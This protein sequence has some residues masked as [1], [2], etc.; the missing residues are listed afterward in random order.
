MNILPASS[1]IAPFAWVFD[2]RVDHNKKVVASLNSVGIEALGE[3]D[4]S[5][6][7]D[8]VESF[9][10]GDGR[11][12]DLVVIDQHWK[13]LLTNLDVLGKSDISLESQ[14][15]VGHALGKYIRSFP[16]LAQVPLVMISAFNKLDGNVQDLAP[17]IF[18]D[19]QRIED[20]GIRIKDALVPQMPSPSASLDNDHILGAIKLIRSYAA[21]LAI[22]ASETIGLIGGRIA[23]DG[24]T[25]LDAETLL[26]YSRDSRDRLE[27]LI[28]IM[29]FFAGVFRSTERT[30]GS[31]LLFDEFT[32]A[33]LREILLRGSFSDLIHMKALIEDK[34]GGPFGRWNQS[35]TN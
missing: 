27:L 13:T 35:R 33:S 28:D 29:T 18:I 6:I 26:R 14:G 31:T 19:K 11:A 7:A 10:R 5:A 8:P 30:E 32:V 16:A 23:P 9:V 1:Q 25:S 3:T 21:D 12:P 2:D 20:I 17:V 4:I 15:L 34:A 22:D 24:T